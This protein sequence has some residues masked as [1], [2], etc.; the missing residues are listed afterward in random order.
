MCSETR[1]FIGLGANV[2]DRRAHI[3]AALAAMAAHPRI[4]IV[5]CTAPVETEPWGVA[6]QPAFLNAVAEVQTTLDPKE[7][8]QSLKRME[9]ELGR[10]PGRRWGPREIDLDILLFRNSVIDD[11]S[12]VIPH[13]ELT[14]RPFVL[15]QLIELDEH[16]V[17]PRLGR[18]LTSIAAASVSLDRA[19]DATGSR[20][21]APSA[22]AELSSNL[23]TKNR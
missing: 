2:G 15:S 9:R 16:L 5:R 8:L 18:L 11:S 1:A 13:P 10:T 21:E 6:D 23:A 19:G 12:L 22:H 4:A 14:T 20:N 3:E 17:H 7:L